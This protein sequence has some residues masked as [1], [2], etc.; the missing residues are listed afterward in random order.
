MRYLALD[1]GNKRVGVA[2]GSTEGGIASPL[3]VIV[4]RTAEQDA[5]ELGALVREY[6]VDEL[7]VG[8]PQNTDGSRGEQVTL[9]QNYADRIQPLL[10]LP[11]QY[12]DER[13][14]T[15]AAMQM[16]RQRGMNEKQG[17]KSVDAA[18]AAVILQDF[19]DSKRTDALRDDEPFV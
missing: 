14:S 3:A 11:L 12:H 13:Y 18:A 9:T 15:A 17:R 6:E 16:Q 5:A 4:R 1:V 10:G 8:L 2:V 7:I 19:L